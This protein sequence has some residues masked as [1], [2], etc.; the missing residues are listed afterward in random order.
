MH[1]RTGGIPD[2]YRRSATGCQKYGIDRADLCMLRNHVD[3]S[4]QRNRILTQSGY[5]LPFPA[6]FTPAL[7]TI[8]MEAWIRSRRTLLQEVVLSPILH[9]DKLSFHRKH[10]IFLI[11][12]LSHIDRWRNIIGSA[13]SKTEAAFAKRSIRAATDGGES[14]WRPGWTL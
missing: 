9:F 3:R 4:L 5:K 13:L 11:T 14:R 2:F 8:G 10:P 6:P 1:R 7:H 12:F